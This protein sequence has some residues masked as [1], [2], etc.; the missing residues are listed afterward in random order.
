L[1][2]KSNEAEELVVF[3]EVMKAVGGYGNFK[4]LPIPA[5]I[6]IVNAME[7]ENKEEQKMINKVKKK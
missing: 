6:E 5:Y 1:Q 3:Y 7:K 4:E 2:H